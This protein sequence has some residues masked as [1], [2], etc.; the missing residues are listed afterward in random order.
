M[1]TDTRNEWRQSV[2]DWFM[3]NRDIESELRPELYERCRQ[4]LLDDETPP[5][6]FMDLYRE[7]RGAG[8]GD[9]A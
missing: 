2:F 4:A 7:I 8:K 1:P 6:D 5:E 9:D 3:R